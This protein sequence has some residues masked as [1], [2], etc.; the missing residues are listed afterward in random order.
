ML[1]ILLKESQEINLRNKYSITN[2]KTIAK[3]T[4][5]I[6]SGGGKFSGGRATQ[7][8]QGKGGGNLLHSAFFLFSFAKHPRQNRD[9]KLKDLL[10]SLV[11]QRDKAAVLEPT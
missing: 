7:L 8:K 9:S 3:H 10:N 1:L 5:T 11:V 2:G 4:A 6:R